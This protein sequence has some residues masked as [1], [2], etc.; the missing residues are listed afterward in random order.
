MPAIAKL[1]VEAYLVNNLKPGILIS[2]DI[3]G[4]EGF[5]LSFLKRQAIISSYRSI[6]FPIKIYTKPH[7]VKSI[8][9]YATK[10]IILLPRSKLSVPVIV[11]KPDQLLTD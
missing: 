3:M 7:R 6:S 11:K 4:L 5:K 8:P 9:I 2:L 10:H 1:I